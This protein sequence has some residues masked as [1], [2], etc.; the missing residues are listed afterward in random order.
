MFASFTM[1][2]NPLFLISF[3]AVF[4]AIALTTAGCGGGGGG[5]KPAAEGP[6]L[7]Q[8]AALKRQRDRFSPMA[9]VGK[10]AFND[11]SLSASGRLSCASCHAADFAHA[12]PNALAVQLG[13]P[14][15]TTQ[16][17][18]ASQSLRYL[19][20]NTAFQFDKHG[21]PSGGFFWDGRA[22]SLAEQAAGPLLGAREMANGDKTA[23]V[24]KIARATWA[25]NFRSLYGA[26]I[27][28][29][30]DRA[31]NKLTEA[32]ARYQ[33]EDA[34]FNA[35]TSKYDAVLRGK[36]TLDSQEQSG[37][38]LFNDPAKGNCAACHTSAKSGNGNHPLFT[39]FSYDNLGVPRNPEIAANAD[40][41]YFDLGLCGRTDLKGRDDLC[42]KFRVPSLRNV[43]LRQSFFHNGRFKS[44]HDA[45]TFYV[46][47]DTNPEKWYPQNLD[48][49]IRKFD[50]LPLQL[51]A[52]VNVTE[53]PYSRNKNDQPSLDDR[54]IADVVA[55]LKTLNDGWTAK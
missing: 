45:L 26:N 18:R 14:D 19:A 38:I 36:A 24:A 20:S 15:M 29:D 34:D 50:D 48:G 42:G 7:S 55:F 30:V 9:A 43:A 3:L 49:S 1:R 5:A 16:G 35:Y 10:L 41:G 17:L 13:G 2:A 27:F 11:P 44:L 4:A 12:A 6:H 28:N 21:A 40:S 25:E 47:R 32:L 46:Q 54:E 51:R 39:D 37:L 23:V 52:N 8:E 53:A 31:F 33:Q 22:N